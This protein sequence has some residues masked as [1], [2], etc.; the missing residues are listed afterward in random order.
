M[1]DHFCFS[2]SIWPDL[3]L[4]RYICPVCWSRNITHLPDERKQNIN[5]RKKILLKLSSSIALTSLFKYYLSVKVYTRDPEKTSLISLSVFSVKSSK[6]L[7]LHR[8]WIVD[9]VTLKGNVF[10][11]ITSHLQNLYFWHLAVLIKSKSLMVHTFFQRFIPIHIHE[12]CMISYHMLNTSY[13]E[14]LQDSLSVCM[15][16]QHTSSHPPPSP[17]VWPL[18]SLL[19]DVIVPLCSHFTMAILHLSGRLRLSVCLSI[20]LPR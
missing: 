1:W 10:L 11:W 14:R 7:C 5:Y 15:I 9:C 13:F 8:A 3:H 2:G 4:L 6:R 18:L 16:C 12:Y 19:V 17:S 20:C